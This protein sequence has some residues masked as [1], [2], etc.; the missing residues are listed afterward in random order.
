MQDE[1]LRIKNVTHDDQ[2]IYSCK[3]IDGYGASGQS[4]NNFTVIVYSEF[5]K[6]LYPVNKSP[7]H[8]Q[9]TVPNTA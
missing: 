9:V 4:Q 5:N 1:K 6:V 2:G 3:P 8:H 7:I